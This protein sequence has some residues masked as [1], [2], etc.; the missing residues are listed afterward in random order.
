M[1]DR[2]E[3]WETPPSLP[4]THYVDNR[5]FTDE[6]VFADEQAR[7]FAGGW[8]LICHESELPDNG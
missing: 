7:I 6:G 2:I 5:I 1:N 4:N 8:K 3:R